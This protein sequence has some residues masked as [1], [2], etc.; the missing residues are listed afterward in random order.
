MVTALGL[1]RDDW[2]LAWGPSSLTL[3]A[4]LTTRAAFATTLAGDVGSQGETD[5]GFRGLTGTP[6]ASS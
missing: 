2:R 4:N 6:W 3:L 5:R 1:S